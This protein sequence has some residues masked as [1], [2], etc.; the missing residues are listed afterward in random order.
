[1]I[2]KL[3]GLDEIHCLLQVFVGS[4]TAFPSVRRAVLLGMVEECSFFFF[5]GGGVEGE[6]L[7]HRD[8]HLCGKF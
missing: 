1:M 8:I 6:V 2:L 5:G 7:S 3:T 4:L